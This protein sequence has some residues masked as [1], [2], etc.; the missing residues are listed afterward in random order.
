M[1]VQQSKSDISS[2]IAQHATDETVI[3]NIGELPSGIENGIAKL[4]SIKFGTYK[5]GKMEGQLF[6]MA[7]G[8]VVSP[9]EVHIDPKTGKVTRK[10][11]EPMLIEGMR[12]Q[13]GPEPL[14]DTPDYK[15][16]KTAGDHVAWALNE[17][18][19]LGLDTTPYKTQKALEAACQTLVDSDV[20]FQ[21]RTWGG[22]T[23]AYPNSTPNHDWKKHCEYEPSGEDVKEKVGN[24]TQK[25]PMRAMKTLKSL[26]VQPPSVWV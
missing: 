16:R 12:T 7:A 2:L 26:L 13:I 17:L 1:A 10:G 15:T 9:T 21:F 4:T 23:D 19:K 25:P 22:P 3:T 24:S 6:F 14:C 8:S 18:R 20:Y 11:G 5:E